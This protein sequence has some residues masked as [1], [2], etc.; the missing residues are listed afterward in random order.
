MDPIASVAARNPSRISVVAYS[1]V[2]TVVID[3]AP[4][5]REKRPCLDGSRDCSAPALSG[6]RPQ[7]DSGAPKKPPGAYVIGQTK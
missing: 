3:D 4:T 1:A 5:G 7:A 2:Y 6:P